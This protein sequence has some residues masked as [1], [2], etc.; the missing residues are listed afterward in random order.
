ML[1][2]LLLAAL[3]LLIARP[4]SYR[5]CDVLQY[6]AKSG[7]VSGVANRSGELV[8]FRNVPDEAGREV[9]PKGLYHYAKPPEWFLF[10][11]FPTHIDTT[12]E[13]LRLGR[14]SPPRLALSQFFLGIS[15]QYGLI[16]SVVVVQWSIPHTSAA[17]L[18]SLP[19]AAFAIARF[20]QRRCGR[21]GRGFEVESEKG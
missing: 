3:A 19:A 21:H 2:L 16:Q 18:C 7:A 15:K 14:R 12:I 17:L 11:A 20:F 13:S 8:F 10:D 4:L 1:L 9:M 5:R 6:T